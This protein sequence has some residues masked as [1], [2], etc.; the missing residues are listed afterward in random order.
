MGRDTLIRGDIFNGAEFS[1]CEKYRYR[2]WRVWDTSLPLMFF[3]LMNPSTADET[4]NDP[5]IERQCRRAKRLGYGGVVILNCGAIRCTDSHT[6]WS[7]EDPIGPENLETISEEIHRHPDSVF[8]AGWGT[9][10]AK[11]GADEPI[12]AMFLSNGIPLW[13]LGINQDGSP[14]HPLYVGYDVELQEY[15]C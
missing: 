2:L 8:V 3:I 6:A 11:Y 5:T 9:P 12:K 15:V 13:S 7:D 14:R 1:T 4:A 10:A